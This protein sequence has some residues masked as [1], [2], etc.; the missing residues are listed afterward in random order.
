MEQVEKRAFGKC[1]GLALQQVQIIFFIVIFKY[2]IFG[3]AYIMFIRT[4]I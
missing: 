4:V 1:F 3:L 2:F